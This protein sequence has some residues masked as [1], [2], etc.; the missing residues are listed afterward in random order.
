M[1]NKYDVFSLF[2]SLLT[3]EEN[4]YNQSNSSEL[5]KQNKLKQAIKKR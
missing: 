5:D 4:E 1:S 3:D 2:E